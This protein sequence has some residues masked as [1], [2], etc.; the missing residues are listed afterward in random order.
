MTLAYAHGGPPLAGTLKASPEDFIVEETLSF[1]ADGQGEHDLLRI[2]KRGANTEWVARGLA[3]FAKVPQVA[4]GFA[5]LKDRH[6][7]ARQHFTVQLPGRAVDWSQLELPGVRVLE[8]ARHSRKL[9]R[10]ALVGNGFELTLRGIEGDRGSAE[11]VLEALRVAG[12]PNYFGTQ[13]F[14]H[15]DGNLALARRLFAG[16]SLG[17]S[18][19]AFALSAARS[20]IFNA[21]LDRRVRE[22]SWNRVIAG[23]LCNLAGKRAWFGPVT[24]DE[25]LE[26]R[27]AEGDIH[28]TGPMW[29]APAAPCAEDCEAL[30]QACAGQ[31]ADLAAGLEAAGVESE[32]RALRM[33]PEALEWAWLDAEEIAGGARSH[34]SGAA[35]V[36]AGSARDL[37]AATLRLRF[38]LP[39]GAY[40][41]SLIRECIEVGPGDLGTS[42]AA[43]TAAESVS[44]EE[45]AEGHSLRSGRGG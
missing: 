35:H 42:L 21:V 14:G 32:R 43:A 38:T 37:S 12:A 17:R 2:E 25:A 6:A 15:D 30:E 26:R 7:V 1:H 10:G 40:A 5:G 44:S 18:D 23:D 13:R 45:V 19:R 41:T 9:K 3:R 16:E 11:K 8:V 24:P 29:G 31:F 36:G 33:I 20:A 39:P 22:G 28:P 4:V 27:C 34:N